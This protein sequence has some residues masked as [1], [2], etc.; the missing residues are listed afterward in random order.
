MPNS[1]GTFCWHEL[2]ASNHA[3]C[4][5]FYSRLIGWATKQS[6]IEDTN[7]TEFLVDGKPVGGVEHVA[8]DAGR[9]GHW[10]VY[11][12]VDDVDTVCADAVKLGGKVISQPHDLL[13]VGRLATIEDP[14]GAQ[15]SLVSFPK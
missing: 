11:L 12:T 6:N 2:A 1:H 7:Y 3:E 13:S 5:D 14:S 15:L 10:R 4:I 9:P 8:G